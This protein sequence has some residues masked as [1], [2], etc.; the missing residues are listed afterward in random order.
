MKKIPLSF[1]AF[2]LSICVNAYAQQDVA[3]VPLNFGIKQSITSITTTA[4]AI[5]ATALSGRKSLIIK[6]LGTATLYIGSSTVTADT[7]ATG[8]FTLAQNDFF[9]ADIGADTVLY[10]I[11]ASGSQNV[12]IIEAR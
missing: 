10:G 3:L 5:P 9:Q 6:N 7:A 11:V 8:G 1:L 2:F 4:T 12:A